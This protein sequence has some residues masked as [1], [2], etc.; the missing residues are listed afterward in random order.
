M[1][2]IR[3]AGLMDAAV[4]SE[5]EEIGFSSSLGRCWAEAKQTISRN[6]V[7]HVDRSHLSYRFFVCHLLQRKKKEEDDKDINKNRNGGV[8]RQII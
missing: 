7:H 8:R 3:L 1:L 6:V 2:Y 5:Q 4:I